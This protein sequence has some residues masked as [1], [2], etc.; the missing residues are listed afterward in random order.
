MTRPSLLNFLLM[1]LAIMGPLGAQDSRPRLDRT[2]VEALVR[3]L[4]DPDF[5]RREQAFAELEALGSTLQPLLRELAPTASVEARLRIETLLERMT[6]EETA[7]TIELDEQRFDLDLR[8]ASVGDALDLLARKA[9]FDFLPD[10]D[11]D[12]RRMVDLELK[13]VTAFEALDRLAR[14]LERSWTQDYGNGRIRFYRS[15]AEVS[16]RIVYRGPFRLS[17]DSVTRNASLTFGGETN[18]NCQ[19]AGRLE[20]EPG[21]PVL[22]LFVQPRVTVA[23]DDLEKDLVPEAQVES[24]QL[25]G[26]RRSFHFALRVEP[27]GPEARKLARLEICLRIALP[28]RYD[29][30]ELE[31]AAGHAE[32]GRTKI[33]YRSEQ[34][35]GPN[36]RVELFIERALPTVNPERPV[37]LA[38]ER[39]EV[40]TAEGE[41]LRPMG[42]VQRLKSGTGEILRFDL[43]GQEGRLRS[44]RL[45]SLLEVELCEFRFAFEDLDLP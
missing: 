31:I 18:R 7:D 25:A 21:A 13:A 39:I 11:L 15:P 26:P 23:I 36:R 24:F 10:P 1:M 32:S 14:Q 35:L 20:I 44:I 41:V 45:A 6:T 2:R 12:R 43:P 3:Q 16:P 17:L 37:E 27:P 4:D 38:D 42:P 33:D 22:G 8:Q 34:K 40:L 28:R 9:G 30:L 19:I 29:P 5:Q